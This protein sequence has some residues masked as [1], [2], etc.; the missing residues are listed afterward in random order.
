[1]ETEV[2][3]PMA[4]KPTKRLGTCVKQ[5]EANRAQHTQ[6]AQGDEFR[7]KIRKFSCIEDMPKDEEF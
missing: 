2:M 3:E 5:T 7:T 6:E 1:M 4:P